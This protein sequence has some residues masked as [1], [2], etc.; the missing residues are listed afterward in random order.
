MTLFYTT[1]T[2]VIERHDFSRIFAAIFLSLKY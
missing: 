2:G 1:F